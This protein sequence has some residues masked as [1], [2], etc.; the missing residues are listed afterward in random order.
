MAPAVLRSL[1]PGVRLAA[2]RVPRGGGG[3]GAAGATRQAADQGVGDGAPAR[4]ADLIAFSVPEG[5]L[6][7]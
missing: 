6:R 1:L 2:A 7:A 5:P 4:I 3:G